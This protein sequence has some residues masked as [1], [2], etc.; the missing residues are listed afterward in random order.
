MFEAATLEWFMLELL[1][2]IGGYGLRT[3]V[4]LAAKRRR[5]GLRGVV[6]STSWSWPRIPERTQPVSVRR[7][8]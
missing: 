5:V 2:H 1:L 8:E 4:F 6:M 7:I 3:R